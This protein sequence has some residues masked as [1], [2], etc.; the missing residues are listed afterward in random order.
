M[1]SFAPSES[2]PRE[3]SPWVRVAILLVSLVAASVV[4]YRTTGAALPT[5]PQDSFLFQSAL[6]LIVLGVSLVEHRF[7]KPADALIN[8]LGGIVA[9]LGVSQ[10]APR[11]A[12]WAVFSYCVLVFVSATVCV[13]ISSG[14]KIAGRQAR[15]AAL[16]YGPAVTLGKAKL[17]YSILFLFGLYAFK[18]LQSPQTVELVLF[19]GLSMVIWPLSLPSLLQMLAVRNVNAS[20][21][22]IGRLVR[23]DWP[24]LVRVA[25]EPG[26]IWERARPA[27]VQHADGLQCMVI[28]LYAQPQDTQ[29]IGTGICIRTK[30]STLPGLESGSVYSLPSPEAS[31]GDVVSDALGVEAGTPLLGFVVENSTIGAIRFEAWDP[32]VCREGMLVFAVIGGQRVLYQITDGVTQEESLEDGRHGF[33]VATAAQIGISDDRNGFVKFP[34][35]PP[36]NAPVFAALREDFTDESPA[37][38]SEYTY[39]FLSNSSIPLVGDFINAIDHHTAILGVTGSGKTELAFDMIRHA[40]SHGVRVVCIDLT[41]RYA[42]RLSDLSPQNLSLT[43]QVSE[44]LGELMF[45]AETGAY[46]AGNEKKALKAFN[47]PLRND[48]R[49]SMNDFMSTARGASLLGL[50]TLEE[51]S[52]TKATLAIT[53]MYL[54]CL[55]ECARQRV[56][57]RERVLV[58]LEEAHTIVP[59]PGTMGLGDYDSRG[60][61][62]KIAQIALQGRKYGVGLLVLS[63]RTAT[64]SKSILTQCNTTISFACIDDTSLG[65]LK[66][67]FGAEYTALLPNLR[68]LQAVAYGK[69][70]RSE[71]PILFDIPFKQEK[72]DAADLSDG[73][74]SVLA[75]D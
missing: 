51:I 63:Q 74:A 2:P 30:T 43:P 62:A 48:V 7:T 46:G 15:I 40:I 57:A 39:G 32:T 26:A 24:D 64:V 1:T 52:N 53:E 58:V 49:K 14:V 8:S 50:I 70:V 59:E 29:T 66:N 42:A 23:T 17:L 34:W 6:L 41:A 3:A 72:K 56:A 10:V 69:G 71:R 5:S 35:L 65:F 20:A 68:S 27:V 67:V 54:S 44:K 45:D 75:A 13:A 31:E 37:A 38:T 16:T 19:W 28:P 12:W 22:R 4:A 21:Q 47:E 25:L 73:R 36:M 18:E 9:L 55:L 11:F 60:M 33:Q 61:V